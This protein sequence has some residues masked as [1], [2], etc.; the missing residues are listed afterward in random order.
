M[1]DPL[2]RIMV[3]Y[4]PLFVIM[5]AHQNSIQMAMENQ[6]SHVQIIFY[7]FQFSKTYQLI[8]LK[9]IKSQKIENQIKV[10]ANFLRCTKILSQCHIFLSFL[11]S[12]FLPCK[13]TFMD[14]YDK[15]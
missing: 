7:D 10:G 9:S 12:P 4:K 3:E 15:I 14:D 1:L 6:T 5:Q 11:Y 8:I 13:N 2:K